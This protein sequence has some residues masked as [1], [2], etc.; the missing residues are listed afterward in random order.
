MICQPQAR[1]M[2]NSFPGPG[3]HLQLPIQ[4][5]LLRT[6]IPRYAIAH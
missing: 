2:T 1:G 3:L 4:E 6:Y 5:V